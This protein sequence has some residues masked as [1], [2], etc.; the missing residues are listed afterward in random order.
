MMLC[1]ELKG[2]NLKGVFN[3][4]IDMNNMTAGLLPHPGNADIMV[5][6]GD[7]LSESETR[8]YG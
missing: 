4:I 6:A 3:V 8:L 5:F 1:A 7:L 2:C